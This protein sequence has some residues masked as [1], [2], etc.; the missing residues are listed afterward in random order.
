M[1]RQSVI[2]EDVPID[3]FDFD[4]F[5]MASVHIHHACSEYTLNRLD[6]ERVYILEMHIVPNDTQ[7]RLCINIIISRVS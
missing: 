5:D 4:S 3:R 6:F 1:T 2:N 7:S